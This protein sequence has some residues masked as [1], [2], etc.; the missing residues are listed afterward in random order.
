MKRYLL[1]WAGLGLLAAMPAL[2]AE[3][4]LPFLKVGSEVYSNVTVTSVTATDIY[5]S[6]SRGL[7]NG[8]LK[9]LD[10][11]MR[12]HF[13]Y[14]ATNAAGMEKKQREASWQFRVD[15]ANQKPTPREDTSIPPRPDEKD[16]FV[17]PKLYAKSFR[18]QPPPQVVIG[19]W[20]TPPPDV[21]GKFVLIDFWA[22]WCGPCRASIPHLNSLQAKFRDKLV[23]IGLSDETPDAVRK[24]TEPQIHYNVGVDPQARTLKAVEVTAIPHAMLIDPKGIVRFE[25]M[26]GYL[27][28][29]ELERLIAQ[30]GGD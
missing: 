25:G 29:Q 24:M 19:E 21:A 15:L 16:D 4:T 20:L 17:A 23:V 8:K 18:G 22:T 5:F 27:D 28:E 7:G 30:Y 26:P 12:K 14:N 13:N 1:A 2:C 6:H 3:E 10:A 11:A 9:N